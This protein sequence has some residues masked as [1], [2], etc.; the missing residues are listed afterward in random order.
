MS[1]L[2]RKDGFF[3]VDPVRCQSTYLVQYEGK[4]KNVKCRKS[5]G[6]L[7]SH[8]GR[9]PKGLSLVWTDQEGAESRRVELPKVTVPPIGWRTWG[10]LKHDVLRSAVMDTPW[11]GPVMT[12]RPRSDGKGLCRVRSDRIGYLTQVEQANHDNGVYS[13]KTLKGLSTYFLLSSGQNSVFGKVEL[14]G[15]VV[16][17]EFGWRAQ[18]VII[19]HLWYIVP[20]AVAHFTEVGAL[21][22]RYQCPVEVLPQDKVHG[23]ITYYTDPEEEKKA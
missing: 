6:H 23:F 2:N 3:G 21:E 13:Y 7:G 16:P 11:E 4:G 8:E 15:H 18:K 12:T 20:S 1:Q 22:R 17:H 5:E 10:L 19:R 14:H 9:S